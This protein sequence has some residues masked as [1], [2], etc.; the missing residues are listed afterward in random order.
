[1]KYTIRNIHQ[2]SR[3]PGVIYA[4]LY[5]P[6]G[7]IETS[8]T[9]DYIFE[10]IKDEGLDVEDVTVDKWGNIHFNQYATHYSN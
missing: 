7:Y 9:L 3:H 2:N 6:E 4:Y 5:N 10:K 8:S 1:M